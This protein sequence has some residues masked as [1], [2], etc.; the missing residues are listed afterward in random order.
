MS[1]IDSM[2]SGGPGMRESVADTTSGTSDTVSASTETPVNEPAP[3]P[4]HLRAKGPGRPTKAMV[5]AREAAG[6]FTMP[7]AKKKSTAAKK[8]AKKPT[9][10]KASTPGPKKGRSLSER[11]PTAAVKHSARSKPTETVADPDAASRNFSTFKHDLAAIC[12]FVIRHKAGELTYQQLLLLVSLNPMIRISSYSL[13]RKKILEEKLLH[14]T[15][16]ILQKKGYLSYL[17]FSKAHGGGYEVGLTSKATTY[18]ASLA[19][20]AKR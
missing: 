17:A 15:V 2:I 5:A 7:P 11:Y 3:I 9:K 14:R 20:A 4:E 13:I 10:V 19:K 6:V 8:T 18:L 1:L 12:K 16:Q